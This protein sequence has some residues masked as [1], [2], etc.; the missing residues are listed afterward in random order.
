MN[1]KS[2]LHCAHTRTHRCNACLALSTQRTDVNLADLL[3]CEYYCASST[4]Q[5]SFES[6]GVCNFFELIQ[7]GNKEIE[8]P[9]TTV[10][11]KLETR[12]LK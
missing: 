10:L 9:I 11:R 3:K 5:E 12:E 4:N 2:E 8:T 1:Y 7:E 6:C